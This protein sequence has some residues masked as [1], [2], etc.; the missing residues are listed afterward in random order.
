MALLDQHSE[1]AI[2]LDLLCLTPSP[3]AEH[4]AARKDQAGQAGTCDGTGGA[5]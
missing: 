5:R 4:A 1:P 2:R 3:P